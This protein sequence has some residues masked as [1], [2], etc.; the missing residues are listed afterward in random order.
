M[1]RLSGGEQGVVP[2]LRGK[3][4][5]GCSSGNGEVPDMPAEPT[6]T[7]VM[8]TPRAPRTNWAAETDR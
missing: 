8:M 5:D 6:N 1:S 3:V 2:V 4:I 7:T